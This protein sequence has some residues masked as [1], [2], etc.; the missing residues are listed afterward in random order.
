MGAFSR[1]PAA[2]CTASGMTGNSR[3]HRGG[4]STR[5]PPEQG[6]TGRP[7][8]SKDDFL[9]NVSRRRRRHRPSADGT[10]IQLGES[11]SRPGST[12]RCRIKPFRRLGPKPRYRDAPYRTAQ[13]NF[14]DN[15]V[16]SSTKAFGHKR[17]PV[18]VQDAPAE[19]IRQRGRR[20]QGSLEIEGLTRRARAGAL[21]LSSANSS[22]VVATVA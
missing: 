5:A 21:G 16:G 9:L 13:L 2:Q 3:P 6:A 10:R 22:S 4:L 1:G 19:E 14:F 8:A 18:L 15:G 7:S 20:A 17:R 12:R 11:A